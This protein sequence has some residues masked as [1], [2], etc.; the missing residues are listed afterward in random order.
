MARVQ[1]ITH[2]LKVSYRVSLFMIR[3]HS[4]CPCVVAGVEN[5]AIHVKQQT[6][7][8]HRLRC[9]RAGLGTSDASKLG[10]KDNCQRIWFV[11]HP[12]CDWKN[13][14]RWNLSQSVESCCS[15]FFFFFFNMKTLIWQSAKSWIYTFLSIYSTP[16]S[17]KVSSN[18]CGRI[19]LAP[20]KKVF[21]HESTDPEWD[22]CHLTQKKDT[23]TWI[24]V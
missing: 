1:L 15:G 24:H 21:K 17:Q 9:L 7:C 13:C 10:F 4:H 6:V 14:Q 23:T 3:G 20:K 19:K 11:L 22:F 12:C 8:F 2:R 5:G 16:R 18:F